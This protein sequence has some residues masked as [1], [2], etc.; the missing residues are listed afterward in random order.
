MQSHGHDKVAGAYIRRTWL[1]RVA[2]RCPSA[3]AAMRRQTGVF[4]ATAAWE[5]KVDS[6]GRSAV[7]AVRP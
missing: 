7:R 4:N 5:L 3:Y 2:A 1:L 6:G